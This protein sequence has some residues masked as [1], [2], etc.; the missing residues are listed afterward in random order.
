MTIKTDACSDLDKEK[1]NV[2][3]AVQLSLETE[4]ANRLLMQRPVWLRSGVQDRP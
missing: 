1:A 4:Q 2:Y 3:V